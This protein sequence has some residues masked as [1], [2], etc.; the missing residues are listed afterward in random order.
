MSLSL[1]EKD[2]FDNPAPRIPVCLVL[3]TSTSM[4]GRPINELNEGVQMFFQEVRED[5]IACDSAEISI[6]TFGKGGVVK[7][8]DFDNIERQQVPRLEANGVTPMG[9]AVEL[10]L[11]LLEQRKK[12]YSDAGVDYYQ[13]WM[14]LMTDGCPTDDIKNGVARTQELIAKKKLT[15]F[16]V[17]IGKDADKDVLRMF[18]PTKEAL[19][20]QNVEFKEF[21]SWLSKSVGS[22]SSESMPG[23]EVELKGGPWDGMKI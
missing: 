14:V 19:V 16:P 1:R 13:P 21:F 7:L 22:L 18:D 5:D 20:L 17:A 2:L 6:V 4:Y 12:E 8:L 15:V 10:A 3:D 23:E 11:D 9:Q